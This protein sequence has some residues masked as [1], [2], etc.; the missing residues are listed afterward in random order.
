MASLQKESD[1][2]GSQAKLRARIEELGSL[3]VAFS[4]G[5]D[6]SYLLAVA[7]EILGDR[8]LA[9]T[10][11]SAIH[12]RRESEEA[13]RF[14]RERGIEHVLLSSREMTLPEFSTNGRDRCY[15]CKR[16]LL[17]Q[18]R[19]VALEWGSPHVAQGANVD[20]L[21]DYRP[22]GKAAEEVGAIAPLVEAGLGKED[23]RVLSREM[24]LPTWDKP[25]MACLATRIPY[26]EI[27]TESK[28]AMIGDA[29]DC[30]AGAGLKQFRVR[31]H[32]TVARIEADP[33]GMARLMQA[34]LMSKVVERFK[35]LGFLYVTLDMEGYLPGS[36]NRSLGQA[37]TTGVME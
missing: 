28:L 8:V 12:P 11:V 29:E 31:H 36:M 2:R 32:G 25:P 10:A 5:V 9:V 24:G 17:L 14:A 7:H 18:I 15:H 22:G 1:R 35:E 6:S 33:A 27:I 26:G 34:D 23:I 21:R 37:K 3:V 19:E 13:R 20:D 30:L 16:S 4:G